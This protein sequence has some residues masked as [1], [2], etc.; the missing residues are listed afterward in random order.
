[1]FTTTHALI[2]TAQTP[3]A[4]GSLQSIRLRVR[5]PALERAAV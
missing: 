5:R 2:T 4:R 3:V 1:M